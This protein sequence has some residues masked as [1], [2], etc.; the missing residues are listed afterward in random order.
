[1]SIP[2]ATIQNILNSANIVEV[3][4]ES[5]RL[6][7]SG[8]NYKA[9]CPFH[10][11]KTASFFVNSEKQIFHCFGC[12]VG[13]NAISFL[14]KM[15]GLTYPDAIRKLAKK[16]SIEI[17]ETGYS[18]DDKTYKERETIYKILEE[19]GIFYQ[20]L[21]NEN[22][23][24]KN[25]LKKRGIN[26][27]TIEKF[28]IGYAPASSKTLYNAAVKKGYSK[29]I[30]YKSGVISTD[31]DFFY[32]RIIFPIF[33]VTGRIIAFG[34]RVLDDKTMPKYLNSPE[35]VVYSKSKTLYALNFAGKSI[36]ETNSAVI[37]EGYIDVIMCHQYGINNTIATLGTALTSQHS[38]ILKRYT[39]NITVAYDPDAA[40]RSSSIRSSE[41]LL[42]NDLQVKI[43]QL[44]N[45]KD[46]DEILI[47]DGADKLKSIFSDSI[48]YIDFLI[49]EKSKIY[50]YKSIEG[51]VDIVKSVLPVIS[52]IPNIIVKSEYIKLLS[53][54]LEIKEELLNQEL[55][56]IDNLNS[57]K[58]I[59]TENIN[60]KRNIS[61]TEYNLISVL[62]RDLELTDKISDI[63]EED[64][65]NVEIRNI[66]NILVGLRKE[67]RTSISPAEL[68]QII[69]S[70]IISQ[71]LISDCNI[72]DPEK[73]I[74]S[75]NKAINL[76]RGR[77]K[78]EQLK[79]EDIGE[80]LRISKMIK[81]TKK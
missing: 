60:I 34:G 37:L 20:K 68:V 21:L 17:K 66:F 61:L 78:M 10:K 24:A 9:C 28:C 58:N 31:K 14:M 33:D 6:V 76:K 15:E 4:E 29:D 8:R 12:N 75:F 27:E 63:T 80:F 38:S 32:N 1:M 65:N 41:I 36:R 46:S 45:G 64:L 5:V 42:A 18:D 13:G 79:K 39:D 74:E 48:S 2:E 16:Y 23:I 50:D 54:K 77:I 25:W 55:H 56:K 70:D 51:K 3:I 69:N 71:M 52:K 44:S 47:S 53:E 49:S 30:L 73:F 62:I 19:A 72:A 67:G 57:N 26:S 40:G 81:G 35:T 7:K 22:T 43:S 11:E 59:Q